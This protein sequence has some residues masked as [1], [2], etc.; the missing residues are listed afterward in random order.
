[1]PAATIH[2]RAP[3]GRS[4][5]NTRGL[6]DAKPARGIFTLYSAGIGQTALDRLGGS[7]TA[8]NSVFTRIFAEQLKRPDLHL[9]DLAVEVRERVAELALKATDERGQPAPHEQTPAYYDQTLGGRIYLAGLPGG[10]RGACCHVVSRRTT[11]AERPVR[12]GAPGEIAHATA[13]KP[14]VSARC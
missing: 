3:A 8:H 11:G 7:D 4:I 5:G 1:M 12:P 14:I 6:A 9:G 2:S 10:G 13:M